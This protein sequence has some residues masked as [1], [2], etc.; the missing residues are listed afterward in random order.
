[1]KC[2]EQWSGILIHCPLIDSSTSIC[3]FK[4]L[5]VYNNK[6]NTC[7]LRK[8]WKMPSTMKISKGSTSRNDRIGNSCQHFSWEKLEKLDQKKKKT[9]GRHRTANKAKKHYKA[10]IQEN[11]KKKPQRAQLFPKSH[12]SI[13]EKKKWW[14]A[15]QHFR[16]TGIRGKLK[17]A[18]E[19]VL[20]ISEDYR[21]WVNQK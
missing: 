15:E 6:I 16:F 7:L 14:E 10:K 13:P 11:L 2:I 21:A 9:F 4:Y 12:V 18:K 8:I 17:S 19:R 5:I 3:Y 1:M 20:G